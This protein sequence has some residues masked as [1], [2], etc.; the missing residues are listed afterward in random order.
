MKN[1]LFIVTGIMTI[2]LF[3]SC[4]SVRQIRPLDPGQSAVNVTLGGP[5][6][7][8]LGMYMPAPIMSVGYNYGIKRGFDL[9]TGLG[10]TQLAFG[11]LHLDCGANWRPLKPKGWVPGFIATPKFQIMTDFTPQSFRLYPDAVLTAWWKPNKI[12][13]PYAG[14][15]NWIEYHSTRPDGNRQTHHWLAAPFIGLTVC[16][17][18]WQYQVETRYYVPNVNNITAGATRHIG[19][20]D[21]GDLG[22][23]IGAGYLF[24]GK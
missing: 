17:G 1:L 21:Y 12:L 13:Y 9:E 7:K 22:V 24:G 14:I 10:L 19:F 6:I 4:S 20:G 15:E 5:I 23:F 8:A 2:L 3:F 18:P 16:R 11:I